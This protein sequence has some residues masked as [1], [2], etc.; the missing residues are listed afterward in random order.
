MS[1][2]HHT[3]AE[4]RIV[5]VFSP[6][7]N[8]VSISERTGHVLAQH[9]HSIQKS[10]LPPKTLF[11]LFSE[12]AH[13][14]LSNGYRMFIL[15]SIYGFSMA[16]KPTEPMFTVLQHDRQPEIAIWSPKP[17]ILVSLELRQIASKFQR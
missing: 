4:G 1:T 14:S 3:A 10:T 16:R 5:P 6:L 9:S 8:D 15:V 12:N 2:L 13:N 11:T 17:E 7:F